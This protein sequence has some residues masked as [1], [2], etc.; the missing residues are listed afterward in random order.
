MP[1]RDDVRTLRRAGKQRLSVA[2]VDR[3]ADVRPM[4]RS[5]PSMW[6]KIRYINVRHEARLCRTEVRD[7]RCSAVVAVG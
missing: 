3:V 2:A 5:S 6:R 7:L 1:H 4:S